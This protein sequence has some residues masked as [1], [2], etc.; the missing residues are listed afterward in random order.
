MKQV[1]TIKATPNYSKSTFTIRKY[2]E[3]QLFAKYR[4][5]KMGKEDF[6]SENMNTENDWKHFLNSDEYYKA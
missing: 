2:I 3:G 1:E 4:T 5:T 6:E